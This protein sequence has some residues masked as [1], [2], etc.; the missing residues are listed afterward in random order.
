MTDKELYKIK[1]GDVIERMLACFIPVYL[2]VQRVTENIIDAGW[3]FDRHTGEEIDEDINSPAS[4][5]RRVVDNLNEL[6]NRKL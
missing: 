1:E 3:I 6:K 4:Y 5:I 2:I